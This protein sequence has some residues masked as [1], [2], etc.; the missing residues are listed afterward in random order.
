M[1]A[2]KNL[3]LKSLG[4]M[5]NLT[6]NGQSGFSIEIKGKTILFDPFITPNE[7]AKHIDIKYSQNT[8]KNKY[9]I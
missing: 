3:K 4:L 7:K 1:S 9:K 2:F 8:F 6:Y 5:K